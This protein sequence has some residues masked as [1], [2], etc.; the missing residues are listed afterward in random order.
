[1]ELELDKLWVWDIETYPNCFLFAITRADG[2]HEK[3]FEVSF[4]SKPV[5]ITSKNKVM[6]W[7]VSIPWGLTTLLFIDS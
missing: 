4:E 2:K 1:M 7:L 6:T 3:V 5:L